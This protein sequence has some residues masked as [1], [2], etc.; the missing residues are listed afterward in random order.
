MIAMLRMT[1]EISV[2][3]NPN[4]YQ[5]DGK[6]DRYEVTSNDSIQIRCPHCQLLGTFQGLG[7]K[8]FYPKTLAQQTPQRSV[9]MSGITR[10]CPNPTCKGFVFTISSDDSNHTIHPPELL[11]FNPEAL[12]TA[13]VQTL[14]EA[15]AC[16]SVRAYR[17]SAMMIRRLLEELCDDANAVGKNLH[18][19]LKTLRTQITLPE[20]LFAAMEELK[21]LGNDAAHIEAKAYASIEKEEAELCIE[22]AQEILKARYQHKSLVDRLRARKL[23]P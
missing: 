1:M 20:E 4:I 14:Q 17:A 7:Y 16:H 15:I 23:T 9:G 21:A 13:L 22:L 18:E 11:D 2:F 6:V 19:R 12:P 8:F 10:M 3:K 5:P